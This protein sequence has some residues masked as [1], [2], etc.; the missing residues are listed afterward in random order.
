LESTKENTKPWFSETSKSLRDN[1]KDETIDY[2]NITTIVD[3]GYFGINIHRSNPYDQSYAI[4][5]W[6]AGCQ[7]FKKS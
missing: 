3:E 6:S 7:V 2:N 5:K 1:N 4:N